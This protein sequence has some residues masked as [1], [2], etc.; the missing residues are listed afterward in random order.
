MFLPQSVLSR[1]SRAYR[2]EWLRHQLTR[3]GAKT[4]R[5]AAT[6]ST[7]VPALD[8]I[9]PEGG[10]R[11]GM[12]VEWLSAARNN[13]IRMAHPPSVTPSGPFGMRHA[14]LCGVSGA[15]TLSLLSAREAC[16]QGSMLVVLDR[17]RMFYPPAAASW[18]ID[19]SRVIVAHPRNA[20]DELWAAVESLRSPIVGAV[21]GALE[22]FDHRALRRLQLAAEAGHALGLF[23][24]PAS[25]RG[26]PTWANVQLEVDR[27]LGDRQSASG[28]RISRV[29]SGKQRG[30]SFSRPLASASSPSAF[31]ADGRQPIAGRQRLVRVCVLRA[32][33]GYANKSTV[34]EIDDASYVVREAA[35]SSRLSPFGYP[36]NL[37]AESR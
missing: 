31:L 12:I 24:R 23:L 20:R 27:A 6:F 9:L 5:E 1:E 36:P 25:V 3:W 22:Q 2:V 26:Q 18:G 33:G 32:P 7:G 19:M 28:Q 29:E 34:L 13:E 16:R 10:W 11:Q 4:P 21:W 35:E 15:A 37:L 14:S 8:R 30:R 17:Q